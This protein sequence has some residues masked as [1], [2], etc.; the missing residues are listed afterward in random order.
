[1]FKRGILALIRSYIGHKVVFKQDR[2]ASTKNVKL[3]LL[4]ELL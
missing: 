4:T 3:I 2:F 1:M